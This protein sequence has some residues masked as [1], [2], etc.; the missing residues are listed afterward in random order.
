VRLVTFSLGRR[1][2]V[3]PCRR[4]AVSPCRRVA[5]S[6]CR[7]VALPPPVNHLSRVKSAMG[8]ILPCVH[9]LRFVK[10]QTLLMIKVLEPRLLRA[11]AELVEEGISQRRDRGLASLRF[12]QVAPPTDETFISRL[13]LRRLQTHLLS[14]HFLGTVMDAAR[15]PNGDKWAASTR[16]RIF[17]QSVD[18]LLRDLQEL[19]VETVTD[20]RHDL[21]IFEVEGSR[22]WAGKERY[23]SLRAYATD[24]LA[25]KTF[26]QASSGRDIPDLF[27]RAMLG[28]AEELFNESRLPQVTRRSWDETYWW[29]DSIH[30]PALG[31]LLRLCLYRNIDLHFRA[32][33]VIVDL[34]AAALTRLSN[35][36]KAILC[37]KAV[38]GAI[39]HV[40]RT[41]AMPYFH[42]A[43]PVEPSGEM[44]SFAA[45]IVELRDQNS[46]VQDCLVCLPTGHPQAE[47]LAAA[48]LLRSDAVDVVSSLPQLIERL[49]SELA[50]LGDNGD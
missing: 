19:V 33:L 15:S 34:N 8:V 23:P 31:S 46:S 17:R 5:V 37:T 9:Q 38:W 12:R 48:V 43:I 42:M 49:P 7:R 35:N 50:M 16:Q 20:E 39:D 28:A 45:D 44:R 1:F 29:S 24:R 21:S 22:L 11:E 41:L 27:E 32:Q 14:D 25:Q 18:G 40:A 3:L 30:W 4:V 10:S 6:P 13:A 36:W 47:S 2:A 26:A